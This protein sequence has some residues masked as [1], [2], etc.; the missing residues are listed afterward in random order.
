MAPFSQH[1]CHCSSNHESGGIL[2]HAPRLLPPLRRR[3]SRR[4]SWCW[5]SVGEPAGA[6]GPGWA[7]LGAAQAQHDRRPGLPE[8]LALIHNW[9]LYEELWRTGSRTGGAP[10]A[11]CVMY[12]GLPCLHRC[13]IPELWES[14]P[15]QMYMLYCPWQP[16]RVSGRPQ[17][18]SSGGRGGR[19]K[20]ASGG[21]GPAE[22]RGGPSRST[23]NCPP[24]P[25][26][27]PPRRPSQ[28]LPPPPPALLLHR[29]WLTSKLFWCPS[30]YVASLGQLHECLRP[31]RL[32]PVSGTATRQ[33]HARQ[34]GGAAPP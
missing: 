17:E 14:K 11:T 31:R 19:G 27:F 10:Q 9:K 29:R 7:A 6:G 16:Q 32:T 12:G 33:Q 22:P 25:F 4:A 26:S 18:R 15:H 8:P 3:Q 1:G 23:N 30:S 20:G 5:M 21:R 24:P 28:N 2:M 34:A 13:S